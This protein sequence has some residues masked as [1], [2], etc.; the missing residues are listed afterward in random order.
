V[1]ACDPAVK[2]DVES[3]ALPPLTVDNKDVLSKNCT[4]PVAVDGESA[5]L[6]VTG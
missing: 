2:L 1:I 3:D 6:N 4:V 5:A